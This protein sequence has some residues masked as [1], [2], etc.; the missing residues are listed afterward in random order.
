MLL[1]RVVSTP[2]V[3]KI[4][5]LSVPFSAVPVSGGQAPAPFGSGKPSTAASLFLQTLQLCQTIV[6]LH[7]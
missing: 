7:R 5:C 4:G 3:G 2:G 6:S 1:F